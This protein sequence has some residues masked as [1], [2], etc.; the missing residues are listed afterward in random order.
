MLA[1]AASRGQMRGMNHRII[2]LAVALLAGAALGI[3][4]ASEYWGGLVPCPLCLWERWPYRI[5]IALGLIAALV[6]ERPGRIVLCGAAVV[7][8]AGVILGG[9]HMG[10]EWKFWPSPLPQCAG[11]DL[12]GLSIMERLARMP[13]IPAK[14][15]D[16]P[17]YLI[18]FLP[19]S[20]AAMNFLL[21]LAMT[22]GLIV[23]LRK[24][25]GEAR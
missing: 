17:T 1:P 23:A 4:L 19:I 6:P 2:G 24:R 18:P 7:L 20:M 25:P 9:V 21:A 14:P 22:A 10:V 11:P 5:L 13:A 12:S 15:C 3:A 8:L 16:E